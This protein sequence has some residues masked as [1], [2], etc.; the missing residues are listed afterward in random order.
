MTTRLCW[1]CLRGKHHVWDCK[2]NFLCSTCKGKH[3]AVLHGITMI[4]PHNNDTNANQKKQSNQALKR[5]A[6]GAQQSNTSSNGDQIRS[7]L[8]SEAS[9]FVPNTLSEPSGADSS[10][11]NVQTTVHSGTSCL[12]TVTEVQLSA[13]IGPVY[14]FHVDSPH[15]ERLVYALLDTQSEKS[16]MFAEDMPVQS[17][18]VRGLVVRKFDSDVKVN[19]PFVYS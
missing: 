14:V 9:P 16:I 1:R 13:M 11:Q 7:S 10:P 12:K 15:S 2:S 3:A 5:R 18:K 8:H 19:L 6:N 4:V 17:D